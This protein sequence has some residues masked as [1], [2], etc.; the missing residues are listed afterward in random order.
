MLNRYGRRSLRIPAAIGVFAPGVSESAITGA[1]L[2]YLRP[3]FIEAIT[4]NVPDTAGPPGVDQIEL[5]DQATVVPSS[6]P[7]SGF[8]ERIH[9]WA[10]AGGMSYDIPVGIHFHQGILVV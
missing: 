8:K 3:G 9:P 10:L 4:V 7:S 1:T 2:V 6:P 5:Y